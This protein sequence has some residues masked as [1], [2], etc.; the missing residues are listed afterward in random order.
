MLIKRMGNIMGIQ[1]SEKIQKFLYQKGIWVDA[2]S[3]DTNKLLENKIGVFVTK[4][5]K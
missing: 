1:Y 5:V 3:L 2:K 4:K